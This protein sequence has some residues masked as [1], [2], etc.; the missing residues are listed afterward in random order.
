MKHSHI[1][2]LDYTDIEE[3]Q[4]HIYVHTKDKR[5]LVFKDIQSNPYIDE[6][7]FYVDYIFLSRR[8]SVFIP[9]EDFSH[10]EYWYSTRENITKKDFDELYSYLDEDVD[11]IYPETL[12]EP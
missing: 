5:M 1:P 11:Y 4:C 8:M 3:E 7:G 10:V 6:I 9:R 2:L 12:R